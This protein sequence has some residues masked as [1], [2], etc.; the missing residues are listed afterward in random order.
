MTSLFPYGVGLAGGLY[1]ASCTAA[2]CYA[3][4]IFLAHTFICLFMFQFYGGAVTAG[5]AFAVAQSA[6]A[7]GAGVG[8]VVSAVAT[9]AAATAAN[10]L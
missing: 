7:T 1:V 5:S 6:G 4:L 8:A 3:L 2:D 10:A 9:G